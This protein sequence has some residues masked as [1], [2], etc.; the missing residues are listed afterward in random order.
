MPKRKGSKNTPVDVN[1]ENGKTVVTLSGPVGILALGG[2]GLIGYLI[3][4]PFL[5]KKD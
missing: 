2:L 5:T 3:V 4:Y 1:K